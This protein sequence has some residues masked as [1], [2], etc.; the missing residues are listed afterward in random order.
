MARCAACN[1]SIL[2]G[3]IEDAGLKFCAQK[4]HQQGFLAIVAGELPAE[5]VARHADEL[6]GGPCPRCG[7]QEPVD[8]QTAHYIWS[9]IYVTSWSSKPELSCRSCGNWRR[10]RAA[11]TCGLFGWWG[12]PMGLL[13]T[14]VQIGRNFFGLF[15]SSQPGEP[16][17]ELLNLVRFNL[18]SSIV[19]QSKREGAD[20]IEGEPAGSAEKAPS[21]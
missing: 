17:P 11:L 7:R 15:R 19:N 3:G 4:C 21:G 16:T 10:V 2:W 8:L 5:E 12:F 14:P 1:T 20:V 9:A 6:R 13:G 18:A